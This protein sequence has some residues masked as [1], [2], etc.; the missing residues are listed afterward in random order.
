MDAAHIRLFTSKFA[1]PI[2]AAAL[3]IAAPL[4]GLAQTTFVAP[5]TVTLQFNPPSG[6]LPVSSS[7]GSAITFTATVNYASGEPT[8]WLRMNFASTTSLSGLTT[9]TNITLEAVAN[10][11]SPA[12]I[13]LHATSPASGIA[14]VSI[15]VSTSGGNPGGGGTS[16]IFSNPG[17]VTT[18]NT[19]GVVTQQTVQLQTNS[20]TAIAFTLTSTTPTSWLTVSPGTGSVVANSPVNLTLQFNSFGLSAGPVTTN[21]VVNYGSSQNLTIPVS[22]TVVNSAVLTINPTSANW[23]SGITSTSI[24]V[25]AGTTYVT[26]VSNAAWIVLQPAGTP[27]PV[28]STGLFLASQNSSTPALT[29]LYNTSVATPTVGIQG[30]VTIKDQNGNAATFTVTYNGTGGGGTV[31]LTPNPVTMTANVNSS[32]QAT[33]TL[34]SQVSGTVNAFLSSSLNN[35]VTFQYVNG[36]NNNVTAGSGFGINLFANSGGLGAQTYSGTLTVTVTS[37]GTSYQATT[38]IN[39]VVGSNNGTVSLT[40]NPV[41]INA[42]VNS[43]QQTTVTLNSQVTGTVGISLSSTLTN[44]ISYGFANGNNNVAAGTGFGITLFTNSN[45]DRK[46]VV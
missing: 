24:V 14:D 36:S 31:S 6:N 30:T 9:S 37:N 20:S 27:S 41:T 7:D 43:S 22:F 19:G 44:F 29:V 32:A 3:L 45:G 13:V 39:F 26:A 1:L 18:D 28:S 4:S 12:T 10:P 35:I 21:I 17:S 23:T 15:T 5:G 38:Q 8:Q 33:V 11:V 25:T 2:L 46:S 16:T 42:P 34:N 40:P